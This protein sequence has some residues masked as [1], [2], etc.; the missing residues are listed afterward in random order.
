M[1]AGLSVVIS[2]A[3]SEP[4]D[5]ATLKRLTHVNLWVHDQNEALAFYTRK[6][7]R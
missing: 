5:T 7:T 3:S 2:R 4:G 6:T 1:A